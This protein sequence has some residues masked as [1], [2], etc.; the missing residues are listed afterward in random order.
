MIFEEREWVNVDIQSMAAYDGGTL[1][2]T[3]ANPTDIVL[4]L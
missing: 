4:L 3:T 2:F 1:R